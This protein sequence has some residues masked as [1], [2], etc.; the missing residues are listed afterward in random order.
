MG[1][2]LL[3]LL[4]LQGTSLAFLGAILTAGI[5]AKARGDSP[6]QILALIFGLCLA[7][8]LVEIVLSLFIHKLERII[9]PTVTG[10]VIAV[11][12]LSLVKVGVT[13]MAGGVGAENVGA[14]RNLAL[15]LVVTAIIL[16]TSFARNAM[17]RLSAMRIGLLTGLAMTVA[18]GM[19]DFSRIGGQPLVAVPEPFKF[20]LAFD[21]ALFVPIAFIYQ[22]TA[23]ETTGDLTANAVIAGQP[24]KGPVYLQRIRGGVL[25]GGIAA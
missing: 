18:M 12:G 8:C 5:V 23:I 24:V 6:E 1:S 17:V 10:I 13:D 21:W 19:V 3:S 20:G 2:G 11:I 4:S 15:A 7:G 14:L 25:G 22:I 16:A 9:T